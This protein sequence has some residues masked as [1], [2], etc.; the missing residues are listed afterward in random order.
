MTEVHPFAYWAS[1]GLKSKYIQVSNWKKPL[2]NN[3]AH[4]RRD[5]TKRAAGI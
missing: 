1:F 3:Q 2:Q 5:I 4:M